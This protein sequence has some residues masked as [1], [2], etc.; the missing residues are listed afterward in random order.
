MCVFVS[1]T[2]FCHVCL[3]KGRPQVNKF[4]QI[5]VLGGSPCDERDV[6]QKT[7]GKQMVGPRLKGFLV[8][9]RHSGC[10]AMTRTITKAREESTWSRTSGRHF[11]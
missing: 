2:V 5:H 7:I 6:A 8:F 9:W 3:L 1:D 4:E 10:T 11:S